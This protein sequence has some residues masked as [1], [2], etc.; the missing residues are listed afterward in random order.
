SPTGCRSLSPRRRCSSVK[1]PQKIFFLL[2][3]CPSTKSLATHSFPIYEMGSMVKLAEWERVLPDRGSY[4]L[5]RFLILRLLGIVYAIAF[6]VAANQ[7][8]P[9]IGSHGLLPLDNF[10]GQVRSAL[11]GS[12]GAFV[13]LPSIFWVNDSDTALLVTA[14]VGFGVSC[15]VAC[16]YANA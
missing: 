7:I 1:D 13:R 5:T 11:G 12:L 2:A 9:L 4:W 16:G 15:V 14:W 10:A 3:S 6:L 8:L